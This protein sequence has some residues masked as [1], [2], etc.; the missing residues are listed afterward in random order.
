MSLMEEM[1]PRLT[2][3]DI[4]GYALAYLCWLC[5]AAI[6]MLTVFQ[7]RDMINVI[8]P[9]LKRAIRKPGRSF[10]PQFEMEPSFCFDR[11]S[12]DM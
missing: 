4:F 6:G 8:W 2:V 1:K 12:V 11:V 7:T 5:T 9:M 10:R 3:G